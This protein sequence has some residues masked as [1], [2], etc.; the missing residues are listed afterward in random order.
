MPWSEPSARNQRENGMNKSKYIIAAATI[1]TFFEAA[2]GQQ[3]SVQMPGGLEKVDYTLEGNVVYFSMS[4]LAALFG[5]RISWEQVGQSVTYKTE[6]HNF[7]F[8]LDSPFFRMDDSVKNLSFPA[9]LNKGQ[10]YLPAETFLPFFDNIRQEQ[11]SWDDGKKTIRF[12]SRRY[13]VTDVA[14]SGKANG[15][16]I[17]IYVSQPLEYDIFTSEGNWL[18]VSISK[19]TVNR[20]QILSRKSST[21]LYD[22]NAVQFEGSTQVSFRLRRGIGKFTHRYLTN[23]GRIQIAIIDTSA[24]AQIAAEPPM[25]GPDAR[26]QKI[27]IDAGHGGSDYGAIGAGNTREK[28]VVLD[29]AK[30]LAKIIRKDKVFEAVLTRDKDDYVPLVDRAN[31]ANLVKGDIFVSIHA[32]ASPKRSARGYQV[33]FLAPAKNDSAR[34]AAQLENAP[35]LAERNAAGEGEKN[36]LDLILSDMIQTEFQ[37]ES[38]DL[39]SFVNRELRKNI[40]E[41]SDR[42]IDQAG[43]FVLNGVYMPSILVETAFITNSGDEKLLDSKNFREKVAEAIYE[44]LKN[45]R[46]KYESAK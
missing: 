19:G 35:F 26:I 45:F 33:F 18:N 39:A 4:Q 37:N 12:D 41:T 44:G 31:K 11:V 29:I 10:L 40:S 15:L 46:D 34:A 22:I 42:G 6:K 24:A 38:D 8:F 21:Y 5:D 14:L 23:P 2:A 1:L 30:R 43:F 7:T 32:N 28:D 16:L 9:R 17:D 36:T 20:R 25:V 3:I 27:I 13:N